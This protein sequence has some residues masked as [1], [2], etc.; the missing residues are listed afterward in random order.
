MHTFALLLACALGGS[1]WAEDLTVPIPPGETLLQDIGV[2]QVAYQSYDGPVVNMPVSYTGH[3]VDPSGIS[4][5][6]GQQMLGRGSIL[7]HSPWK[8]PPGRTFVDYHLA[9]PKIT[10]LTLSFGITMDPSFASKS[11]GVTFSAALMEN[12]QPKELMRQFWNQ[13]QWKDYTFDLSDHAGQEIILRLQVEPG[14]THNP[15][16]AFS[17]F[18]DA[19][20]VAGS[21]EG[22]RAALLERLTS[23]KAYQATEGKSLAPLANRS[24]NGVTPGNLLAAENRLVGLSDAS[25]LGGTDYLFTY[26]GEDCKI[27]YVYYPR[28]GTLDDLTVSVDDGHSF[29]PAASGGV[30]AVVKAE[31]KESLVP[32]QGGKVVSV[33]PEDGKKVL[34]V[35]WEYDL[36]GT[37]VRIAWKFGIEGKALTIS[38]ACDSPVIAG[39]SLGRV[40]G[41][42]LRRSL[43]V[44]YLPADWNQ[45]SLSYLPADNVYVCRYLDWTLSQSSRCPQ[46]EAV[47]EPKTDGTRNPLSEIGY[48][49]VSPLVGEV[50][51]NVPWPA[52]PYRGLV[53]ARIMLDIWGQHQGTFQGSADNLRELKDNGIDHL[54]I[55]NHDWQRYGYDTKLPNH[56][57]ANPNYGGEE[58]MIAFGKAANECGYV[59]SLHE[60][61]IDLYP[62]APSYDPTARVLQADGKPSL[63]WFNGS[64]Q[65]F[66]LKTNRAQGYAK[67]NAP[68]EHEHYKTSAAYLDVHTCVPPWHQL[69]HEASQPN[70]AMALEKVHCDSEL[71]QYMRDTHGGPLFGE[72]A[73][74]FYWAGACDGVEGQVAGGEHHVPLVDLDLLKLHPQMTNHGMG[75]YERWFE[76]GYNHRWGYDTGT[77]EQVDKYRAQELAYGHAGFV[78]G[79]Q[80][81]NIQWVAKEHHLM[82][83]VQRLYGTAKVTEISYEVEGKM[84]SAAV[85]LA[86]GPTWRQRIRYDSGLT[87]WVNWAQEPW[88]VEGRTLPRWGFLALGPDTEVCTVLRDGKF[89]DWADCPEYLFAD[90]RTSF[91]MPYLNGR[92]DIE[93]KLKTFEDLGGGRV[94]LSYEW[95]VNDTLSE[96]DVAFVHF[97]NRGAADSAAIVFQQDHAPPIPT[98]QW[99]KGQIIVDGPYEITVPAQPFDSYDIV[100]GLYKGPRVSLKGVEESE[101]RIFLGRMLVTREGGKVTKVALADYQEAAKT[102]RQPR[103]DF[104]AHMNPAGTT[105]DWGKIATDGSVKVNR[106]DRSLVVFPYPREREFSV[107]LDVKAIAPESGAN[108]AKL[109]VRALAAG[110]GAELGPVDCRTEAGRLAFKVGMKGAGRYEVSW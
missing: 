108:G 5:L 21:T 72:G 102:Y 71:F 48:V 35:L 76:R 105:V 109:K 90:A 53:G 58:G 14:P 7:M 95:T 92:K 9:L 67:M 44:P 45:G 4:Y 17:Y 41:A 91:N 32:L 47:Y 78:G 52:S 68:Y 50:L 89:A 87:L 26:Q 3:F 10:P 85:A 38:A 57:P 39:F 36:K 77:P 31:G 8:V 22:S 80:V 15:S 88:Q 25:E 63:A 61:Y 18:G 106:G 51:P 82:H 12:G 11:E 96:D 75:Y 84:V 55:I 79:A 43:G 2:Y 73:N 81:D 6:P 100:I 97:I 42:A 23:C 27:T 99:R 62:D 30:T 107:A 64:V 83:P 46:G 70:A 66:G 40:A 103:A 65:S 74:Q 101:G 20:I 19:K 54:V 59:W 94:R 16:F 37:P 60:N 34:D 33:K 110:T 69:D 29:Q 104:T 24:G 98:S 49:A 93:P 56:V 86:M 1:A 13:G 28:T